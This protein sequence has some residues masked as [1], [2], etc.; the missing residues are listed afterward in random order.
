MTPEINE[1][2]VRHALEEEPC[3]TCGHMLHIGD[4][5][6]WPGNTGATYCSLECLNGRNVAQDAWRHATPV[7]ALG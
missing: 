4:H 1:D 2:R 5:R 3:E 6:F 7:S